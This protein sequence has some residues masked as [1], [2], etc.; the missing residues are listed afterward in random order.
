MEEL[1]AAVAERLA[2]LP[3]PKIYEAEVQPDDGIPG[4]RERHTEYRKEGQTFY[5]EGEWLVNLCGQVNF[6]DYESLN[7]F[8]K[9]LKRSGVIDELLRMGMTEGDTVSVYGFEFDWVE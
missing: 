6:S 7:F 5:V 9:V 2:E 4:E 3:P 1:V 8:R